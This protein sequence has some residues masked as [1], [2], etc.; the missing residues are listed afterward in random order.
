MVLLASAFR[1]CGSTAVGYKG[2]RSG[3]SLPCKRPGVQCNK[4]GRSTLLEI[5]AW[6]LERG[7]FEGYYP[8]YRALYWTSM[9][10]AGRVEAEAFNPLKPPLF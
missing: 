9:S 5:K 6:K 10:I 7:P 1:G 8:R 2:A 3:E 4:D